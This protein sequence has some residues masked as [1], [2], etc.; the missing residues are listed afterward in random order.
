MAK[1]RNGAAMLTCAAV[2]LG[3]ALQVRDG[4]YSPLAV[5][6]LAVTL[7]CAVLGAVLA[8]NGSTLIL[9]AGLRLQLILLCTDWPGSHHEPHTLTDRAPFVVVVVLTL[10]L[11]LAAPLAGRVISNRSIL[12]CFLALFAIAS[13][14]VLRQTRNPYVDVF[15]FQR[16]ACAAILTGR[17]PYTI[18]FTTPYSPGEAATVY[19]AGLLRD[20]QLL[21]GYPY[22]PLTLAWNLPAHVILGDYRYANVL[23]LVIAAVAIAA[24]DRFSV[25]AVLASA[26]LLFTPRIFYIIEQGWTEPLTVMLLSLT[27]LGATRWP[28]M[29]PVAFG[30][31][32]ASKQY[33][34][35]F[36]PLAVLLTP[37][38][39]WRFL[40]AS[41]L[42]AAVVTVPLVLWNPRAF[43]ESA[44]ALQ[45]RQPF[46]TDSL[47]F[48]A[49]L[50]ALGGPPIAA[51]VA[52][53]LALLTAA[54]C[55]WKFERMARKF[56][57][58]VALTCLVF[59]TLGKQAFGN[60][61]LVVIAALCC[62][63]SSPRTRG[64][65]G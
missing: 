44:V 63:I 35:L 32:L 11:H 28:A 43:W 26:V 47:S 40:V 34:V 46:R 58:A 10:A 18:S 5:V 57:I 60:Y 59:F 37:S 36:L 42:T 48:S 24:T 15:V 62:A 12:I 56:A 25:R 31:L 19:G 23:A 49:A 29:T 64:E 33:A 52:P 38:F 50:V 30:L 39:S 45:F 4:L 17:N 13:I 54:F 65:A 1:L 7:A 55:A 21:F 2:A 20:G 8:G 22:L 14:W 61:Y 16:D 3:A 53:L 41:L 27:I 6:L 51:W 9:R